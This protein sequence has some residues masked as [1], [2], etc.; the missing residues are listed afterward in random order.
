MYGRYCNQPESTCLIL[1]IRLHDLDYFIG[2]VQ[3]S[4]VAGRFTMPN[5]ITALETEC[6]M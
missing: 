5:S 4:R 2:T 1:Y 6:S 3:S